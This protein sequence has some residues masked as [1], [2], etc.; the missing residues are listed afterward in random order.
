[1]NQVAMESKSFTQD[2]TVDL[3]GRPVLAAKTGKWKACS[4]LV[5]I[6]FTLSTHIGTEFLEVTV[7]TL[8]RTYVVWYMMNK[9]QFLKKFSILMVLHICF[10]DSIFS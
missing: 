6:T 7:E 10:S 2:G 3:H 8:V 9:L 5:G 4:F 1:M